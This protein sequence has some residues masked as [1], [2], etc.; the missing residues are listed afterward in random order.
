MTGIF[1]SPNFLANGLTSRRKLLRPTWAFSGLVKISYILW[2]LHMST[3]FLSDRGCWNGVSIMLRLY[4]SRTS[5]GRNGW[6]R[7]LLSSV[8]LYNNFDNILFKS[9]ISVTVTI[10]GYLRR[11]ST[12]GRW[13]VG[14]AYISLK[15]TEHKSMGGCLLVICSRH[16]NRRFRVN[17]ND[18]A[19]FPV[20]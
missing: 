7:L 18:I 17:I 2:T 9:I 20:A 4:Y 16:V 5:A 10:N 1:L 13:W 8:V 11:C 3:I 12:G 15:T 6:P 14:V 19:N